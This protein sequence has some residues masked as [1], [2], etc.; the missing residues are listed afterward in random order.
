LSS[1]SMGWVC[2]RYSLVSFAFFISSS[3]FLIN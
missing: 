3:A 1:G 2:C